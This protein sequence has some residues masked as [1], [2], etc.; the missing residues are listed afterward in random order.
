ML[1]VTVSP[2]VPLS[3]LGTFISAVKLPVA[4]NGKTFSVGT[5][6]FLYRTNVAEIL[7]T[8]LLLLL[9]TIAVMFN[10][11]VL[12]IHCVVLFPL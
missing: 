4:F 9:V 5:L 11:W 8:A 2:S 6:L 1:L 10:P 7:P 12:L 3:V